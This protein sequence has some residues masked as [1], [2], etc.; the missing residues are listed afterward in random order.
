MFFMIV[1]WVTER[2]LAKGN[3]IAPYVPATDH[4]EI[5]CLYSAHQVSK[6]VHPESVSKRVSI[7]VVVVYVGI[8]GEPGDVPP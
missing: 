1:C 3:T 2:D 6:V 8:V 4:Q 7:L 5:F